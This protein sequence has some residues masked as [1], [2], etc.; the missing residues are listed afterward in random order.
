MLKM[1][2]IA[3]GGGGMYPS[4]L[5]TLKTSLRDPLINQIMDRR[6]GVRTLLFVPN[7]VLQIAILRRQVCLSSDV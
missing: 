3:S 2:G 1:Q 5:E 6:S 7:S 4:F